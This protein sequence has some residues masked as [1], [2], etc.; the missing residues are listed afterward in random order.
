VALEEVDMGKPNADDALPTRLASCTP[1]GGLVLVVGWGDGAV[2]GLL[3]HPDR[4]VVVVASDVADADAARAAG[5]VVVLADLG[6]PGS[7]SAVLSQ[8][9]GRRAEAVVALDAV[10]AAR[11]T[12][13][14]LDAAAELLEPAGVLVAAVPSG[15]QAVAT[16]PLRAVTQEL[17]ATGWTTERVEPVLVDGDADPVLKGT[18]V[19][20]RPPW[21]PDALMRAG[22]AVEAGVTGPAAVRVLVLGETDPSLLVALRASLPE[23]VTISPLDLDDDLDPDQPILVLSPDVLPQPGWIQDLLH[24]LAVHGRPVG[25]RLVDEDG[26][27]VHAGA[28]PDGTPFAAGALDADHALVTADRPDATLLPPFAARARDLAVDGPVR[29]RYLGAHPALSIG[30][31]T[32]RSPDRQVAVDE[33]FTD[34]ALVVAS[35]TPRRF[36]PA[37]RAGLRAV[38]DALLAAG[39]TPVV[40]WAE[41]GPVAARAAL[42]ELE[43]V[44]V[45]LVGGSAAEAVL[46]PHPLI[47][48]PD[49]YALVRALRPRLVAYADA[50]AMDQ[51][52]GLCLHADDR[53]AATLLAADPATVTDGVRTADIVAPWSTVG[54]ADRV[55]ALLRGEHPR[56]EPRVDAIPARE[57]HPGVVSVVIPVWNQWELTARCLDSLERHAELPL[58]IVVVDNGSTDATPGEL[59]ARASAGAL[60]V[61]T[62]ATNRGFPAACNQG[63]RAATGELVCILN[64]DTEV[65]PGWLSEMAAALAR[66]GTGMVGPRSNRISGPQAVR[67]AP[68]IDPADA[69]GEGAAHAWAATWA[70]PRAGR[71]WQTDRLVGFCLLLR[72]DLLEE[73]G[74]FDEAFG[75]GNYEDDD[76]CRR[77]LEH[78]LTLRVADASVVLHRGGATFEALGTS[79][80]VL[81]SEARRHHPMTEVRPSATLVAAVVLSDGDPVGAARSTAMA[82]PL[83][84]VVRVVERRGLPMTQLAVASAF[85][86]A[87]VVAGG[88]DDLLA[89]AAGLRHGRVLFLRAGE[90]V[91]LDDD[92]YGAARSAIEDWPTPAVPV[93]VDGVAE[94][95]MVPLDGAS[96]ARV[97][98]PAATALPGV[99]L[100]RSVESLNAAHDDDRPV[101]TPPPAATTA[102]PGTDALVDAPAAAPRPFPA[103]RI[104]GAAAPQV[105]IVT[106]VRNGAHWL[107]SYI[108]STLG[109]T[110]G[111]LEV[112]VTDNASTDGTAELL[113]EIAAQDPRLRVFRNPTDLGYIASFERAYSLVRAPYAQ[114]L[115]FDDEL[116]PTCIERLVRPLIDHP[117][118]VASVS[119]RALIDDQGRTLSPWACCG[120]IVETDQAVSGTVFAEINLLTC[121]NWVGHPLFPTRLVPVG[122]LWEF[123]GRTY[124]SA[125]D[126]ASALT[127]LVQGP[128]WYV[129]DRLFRFRCHPGQE[130]STWRRSV[131][132]ATVWLDLIESGR[133]M[134]LLADPA[135]HH[136]A[137]TTFVESG[138][139]ALRRSRADLEARDGARAPSDELLTLARAI[140]RA[141]DA[142]THWETDLLRPTSATVGGSDR[143]MED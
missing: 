108:E 52:L 128:A 38:L 129:T 105:A 94:V 132:N 91:G 32:D 142:L 71:S 30:I 58:E 39:T 27:V 117:E 43:R 133:S 48:R 61:V 141:S 68:R 1:T 124:S 50:A 8:L 40:H 137:L 54:L 104:S 78:G 70:G 83:V 41:T 24:G 75:T 73:L 37:D 16:A 130:G 95:R 18:L 89:A 4:E 35:S 135:Q 122:T 65:T 125:D 84:D 9:D 53:G 66:P 10:V 17:D 127:L 103:G 100:H 116:A 123:A 119:A 113:E 46:E 96:V 81:L 143:S 12:T 138:V 31:A 13:T 14:V 15:L 115:P 67:D 21:T 3:A 20:A 121:Q 28:A 111:D 26:A 25:V 114:L 33:V 118:L 140:A 72:G 6:Q 44:G 5:A 109:Q 80:G 57:R 29:G 11:R 110:W 87:E 2:A 51:H 134:G 76:L 101:A 88:H 55:V 19:V 23:R 7:G 64:N 98:L 22:V 112:V 36:A 47:A 63:M 59:A 79:Y 99:R 56:G 77:V 74:G 60:T 97:G 139:A 93:E 120:P 107:P 131:L 85:D 92:D 69:V 62:N 34:V 86:G 136:L 42:E 126:V 82:S 45:V 49:A 102:P 90:L 106:S